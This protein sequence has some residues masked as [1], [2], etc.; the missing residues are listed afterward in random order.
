MLGQAAT[1]GAGLAAAYLIFSDAITGLTA[2]VV[3]STTTS[4]FH[5][6]WKHQYWYDRLVR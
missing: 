2:Q 6:A 3:H 4:S 1:L 5:S